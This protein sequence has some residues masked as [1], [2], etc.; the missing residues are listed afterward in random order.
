[1]FF[2]PSLEIYPSF[3]ETF[4]RS[5]LLKSDLNIFRK[6]FNKAEIYKHSSKEINKTR[7]CPSI[8]R[9]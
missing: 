2:I 6:E 7:T 1:M 5:V 9:N 4:K 8:K 3:K